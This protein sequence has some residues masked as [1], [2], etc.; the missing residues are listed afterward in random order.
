MRICFILRMLF[1]SWILSCFPR[2][3]PF[4]L[5][6]RVVDG[7]SVSIPILHSFLCSQ[8]KEAADFLSSFEPSSFFAKRRR[9][10]GGI[11]NIFSQFL[12]WILS[13]FPRSLP[14]LL[15]GRVVDGIS[16]SIPILNSFLC[17]QRKEA[18]DFLSSFEPSSFFAKRRRFRGGISNIFSQ[19]LSWILSCF[20][21]SLP[22]LLKGRVGDGI[23]V[24][25]PILNSFLC[26]QR[27]EAADF[28]SS[29]EPS[30]FFAKRKGWGWN[31]YNT[32]RIFRREMYFYL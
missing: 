26:S 8:R 16:V 18:A 10:R 2:S 17:S 25:I 14:F 24:S 29:F 11:S 21:R 15:K 23:S 6:G 31:K 13:C 28:L 1:L 5:K 7:I 3:L 30:S 32:S 4:L 19:F 27:K 12:S 20:P 9:F 22:F